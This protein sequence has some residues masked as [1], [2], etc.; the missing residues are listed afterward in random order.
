[1]KQYLKTLQ[2]ALYG[3]IFTYELYRIWC[4]MF[5]KN[6]RTPWE[7][8]SGKK[9]KPR[10]KPVIPRVAVCITER[11]GARVRPRAKYRDDYS[12]GNVPSPEPDFETVYNKNIEEVNAMVGASKTYG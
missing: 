7:L 1:M 6:E 2:I 9:S 10:K 4:R 8:I 5:D 11:D 12:T 3:S